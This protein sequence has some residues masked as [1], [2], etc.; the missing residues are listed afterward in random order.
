MPRA[1]PRNRSRRLSGDPSPSAVSALLELSADSPTACRKGGAL[2]STWSR[3]L[4]VGP[5][6]PEIRSLGFC[7]WALIRRNLLDDPSLRCDGH[8][9]AEAE[10]ARR[11][12]P[13][14]FD[15]DRGPNEKTYGPCSPE[16]IGG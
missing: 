5:A 6:S 12:R 14:R 1:H 13:E 10:I 7:G 15:V 3:F 2:T 16:Q 8:A 4:A 11:E 9:N